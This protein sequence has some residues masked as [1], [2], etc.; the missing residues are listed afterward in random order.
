MKKHKFI[1]SPDGDSRH[2][3]VCGETH[4]R[5]REEVFVK[6]TVWYAE[7]EGG[8]LKEATILSR[9]KKSLLELIHTTTVPIEEDMKRLV[10]AP[11][12]VPSA[13]IHSI[14]FQDGR[15]WDEINGW[16]K[17]KVTQQGM[18][19]IALLFAD[20]KKSGP[21]VR[22]RKNETEL[23][24]IEMG[25]SYEQEEPLK[26]KI[27]EEDIKILESVHPI[28]MGSDINSKYRKVL[29]KLMAMKVLQQR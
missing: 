19:A 4:G 27:T 12:G 3:A 26:L 22:M 21:T 13:A 10:F 15:R 11:L 9:Q 20:R 5:Q 28:G 1:I 18:D 29:H 8:K 25:G 17:E 6:E 2:C 24:D 23:M 14:I 16:N 7:E